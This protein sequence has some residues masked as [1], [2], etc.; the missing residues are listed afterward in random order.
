[1]AAITPQQFNV[2][3]PSTV[4]NQFLTQLALTDNTF[5]IHPRVVAYKCKSMKDNAIRLALEEDRLDYEACDIMQ[6][7]KHS[8]ISSGSLLWLCGNI[9]PIQQNEND[10]HS[11]AFIYF[12]RKVFIIDLEYQPPAVPRA[13]RLVEVPHLDLAREFIALI[14]GSKQTV[15]W[16]VKCWGRAVEHVYLCGTGHM[17]QIGAG[18]C[19]PETGGWIEQCDPISTGGGQNGL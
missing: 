14:S 3:T 8:V 17:V 10:W 18:Q 13:R 15:R 11:Y 9:T 12:E 7:A 4:I 5:R 16:G 2:H 19:N 1:M 6:Q